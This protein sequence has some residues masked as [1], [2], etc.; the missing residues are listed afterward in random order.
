MATC[1]VLA[2]PDPKQPASSSTDTA[3]SVFGILR[4]VF[5][6][7]KAFPTTKE[8]GAIGTGL[9][10]GIEGECNGSRR[11]R[12]QA[13]PGAPRLA[14][15]RDIKQ[16]TDYLACKMDAMVKDLN[17]AANQRMSDADLDNFNSGL[18]AVIDS[19]AE[20]CGAMNCLSVAKLPPSERSKYR[21][22]C[23][24]DMGPSPACPKSATFDPSKTC[25]F[26][27]GAQT[28]QGLCDPNG[29]CYDV[30]K[31]TQAVSDMRAVVKMF[32]RYGRGALL[33]LLMQQQLIM[34]DG[35]SG[36]N[37]ALV[38]FADQMANK[39]QAR[40]D[41][42]VNKERLIPVVN[43]LSRP[44]MAHDNYNQDVVEWPFKRPPRPHTP[45][46]VCSFYM[47]GT[48]FRMFDSYAIKINAQIRKSCQAPAKVVDS[49]CPVRKYMETCGLY[50]DG[51]FGDCTGAWDRCVND[52]NQPDWSD[53]V[54]PW[55]DLHKG[56]ARLNQER[57]P[58]VVTG[59]KAAISEGATS[60]AA[61]IAVELKDVKGI[62]DTLRAI[63]RNGGMPR[64]SF[65]ILR[66]EYPR[67][68]GA[69]SAN[70]PRAAASGSQPSVCTSNCESCQPSWRCL[71]CKPGYRLTEGGAMCIK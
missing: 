37:G 16:S 69:C 25:T 35:A 8:I 31:Y 27:L 45:G 47:T 63:A 67:Y 62:I 42:M 3:K 24:V 55:A 17:I 2:L 18:Q 38:Q 71:K 23:A 21:L 22:D 14:T 29:H 1:D 26:N 46:K 4:G 59:V 28:L 33:K 51:C 30:Y 65:G 54:G 32:A 19:Y 52:V 41:Y 7:M 60:L 49:K 44:S 57:C 13:G 56:R 61:D 39:L 40:Y 11:Q 66:K 48:S 53:F 43:T 70:I 5:E 68:A 9:I 50:S 36:D 6:V 10:M 15:L 20:H 34:L 58:D 64:E 12:Q